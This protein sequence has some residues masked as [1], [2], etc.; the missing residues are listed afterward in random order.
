VRRV[1]L[2][3][4]QSPSAGLDRVGVATPRQLR[5]IQAASS[6]GSPQPRR[7]SNTPARSGGCRRASSAAGSGWWGCGGRGYRCRPNRREPGCRQ[8]MPAIAAGCNSG[9]GRT[10]CGLGARAR[11]DG[12]RR[13][14]GKGYRTARRDQFASCQH[15]VFRSLVCLWAWR[16]TACGGPHPSWRRLLDGVLTRCD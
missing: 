8:L 11:E 4:G 9:A 14:P 15:P 13:E 6:N 3:V 2:V 7:C 1:G 10:N 5:S 16:P 12:C